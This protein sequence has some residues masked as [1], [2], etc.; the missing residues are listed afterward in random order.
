MSYTRAFLYTCQITRTYNCDG[1]LLMSLDNQLNTHR[2]YKLLGL[3]GNP[4]SDTGA[5][6]IVVI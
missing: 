2:Y 1:S 6:N 5:V 4:E 3:G